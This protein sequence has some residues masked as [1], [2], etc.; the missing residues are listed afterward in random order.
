MSTSTEGLLLIMCF[1]SWIKRIHLS[2]F[3]V[4]FLHSFTSFMSL[5]KHK[6]LCMLL[7]HFFLKFCSV[8]SLVV[9]EYVIKFY[10]VLLF[11]SFAGFRVFSP[12]AVPTFPAFLPGLHASNLGGR[13]TRWFACG[14]KRHYGSFWECQSR[15]VCNHRQVRVIILRSFIN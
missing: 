8:Y 2:L 3:L 13:P 1:I 12:D 11:V 5:F 7:F 9:K 6:L 15:H 4:V 14:G 10:F